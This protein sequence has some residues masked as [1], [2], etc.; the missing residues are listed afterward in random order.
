LEFLLRV[1]NHRLTLIE[2]H[3]IERKFST[4]SPPILYSEILLTSLLVE[5]GTFGPFGDIEK[6][7]I[8]FSLFLAPLSITPSISLWNRILVLSHR[9]ATGAS[10]AVS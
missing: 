3:S 1:G 6:F 10:I 7:G 2:A 4:L 8:S 5:G 9:R